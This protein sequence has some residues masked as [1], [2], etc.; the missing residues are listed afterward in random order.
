MQQDLITLKF[1]NTRYTNTGETTVLFSIKNKKFIKPFLTDK[2]KTYIYK[3]YQGKYI[4]LSWKFWA[5]QNPPHTITLQLIHILSNNN[6]KIL[7]E[8]SFIVT[9]DYVFNNQILNDFFSARPEYHN[10]PSIDFNKIYTEEEVKQILDFL[11][12]SNEKTII[13]NSENM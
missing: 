1:Y 6:I 3:I 8:T 10:A 7:E 5:K 2:G 4:M 11:Q 9:K 13:E 12:K